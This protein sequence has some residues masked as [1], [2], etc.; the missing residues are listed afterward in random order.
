MI[1]IKNINLLPVPY[2]Y[3]L[4]KIDKNFHNFNNGQKCGYIFIV[5]NLRHIIFIQMIFNIY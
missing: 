1:Q 3:S 2:Q 5:F 4:E